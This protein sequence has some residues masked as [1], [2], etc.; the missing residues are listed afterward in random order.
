MIAFPR[1]EEEEEEGRVWRSVEESG[2]KEKMLQLRN[3]KRKRK[4]D[5]KRQ[6]RS[7][8]FFSSGVR[9]FFIW[10]ISFRAE[11]NIFLQTARI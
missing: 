7:R 2:S 8:E 1:S 4:I 11:N 3:D 5:R 9:E 6:R 10:Q